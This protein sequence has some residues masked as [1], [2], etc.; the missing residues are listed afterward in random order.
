MWPEGSA[1]E[2]R[3]QNYQRNEKFMAVS[4]LLW[5]LTLLTYLSLHPCQM[6]T[7]VKLG[8][9]NLLKLGSQRPP[10]V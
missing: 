3:T 2:L 10:I 1:V 4:A 8:V 6:R 5:S 7:R 9:E